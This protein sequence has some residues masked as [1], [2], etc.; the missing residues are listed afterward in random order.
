M[1]QIKGPPVSVAV[2]TTWASCGYPLAPTRP[3]VQL[4]ID[5]LKAFSNDRVAAAHHTTMKALAFTHRKAFNAGSIH[6]PAAFI[7]TPS[8]VARTAMVLDSYLA[9]CMCAYIAAAPEPR[10]LDYVRFRDMRAKTLKAAVARTVSAD[11]YAYL[12]AC[13]TTVAS[14]PSPVDSAFFS[15]TRMDALGDAAG[16]PDLG[17]VSGIDPVIYGK[18]AAT[19]LRLEP[20]D[21]DAARAR[22]CAQCDARITGAPVWCE[23]CKHEIMGVYCSDACRDAAKQ[24]HICM[25]ELD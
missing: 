25:A 21:D 6:A 18:R 9:S 22:T 4:I 16:A 11:E 19:R 20:D 13:V 12:H 23:A 24:K 5:Q 7:G 15:L 8:D 10:Y 3:T 14:D 17:G 1:A 2:E